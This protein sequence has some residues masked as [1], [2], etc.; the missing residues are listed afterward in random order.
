MEFTPPPER[1]PWRPLDESVGL[2]FRSFGVQ[3]RPSCMDWRGSLWRVVGHSRHWSTWR[4]LPVGSPRAH[5]APSTRGLRADFWRFQ[6]QVDPVSPVHSFEVRRA[7]AE[8]RLVRLAV[9]FEL[10]RE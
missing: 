10:P 9:T 1:T 6:A 3:D 5:E 2:T 8:W 4:F 7:E